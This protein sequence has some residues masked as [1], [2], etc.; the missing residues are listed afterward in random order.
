MDIATQILALVG[1]ASTLFAFFTAVMEYRKSNFIKRSEFLENLISQMNA[2]DK[3]VALEYLDDFLLA[4]YENLTIVLRNHLDQEV[5]D[6][7]EQNIRR[8]FDALLD[9]FA[10]LDYLVSNGLVRKTELHYFDYYIKRAVDNPAV[11]R[12]AVI[13]SFKSLPRLGYLMGHIDV[14][15]VRFWSLRQ[16]L[17]YML[18]R[19][20]G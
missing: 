16:K 11:R 6:P 2:E 8:S 7:T 17:K 19:T 1:A 12:Y 18:H 4:G 10:R 9:F 5:V 14:A 20:V 13:Y 3:K 15:D